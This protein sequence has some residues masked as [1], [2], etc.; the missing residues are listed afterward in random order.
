MDLDLSRVTGSMHLLKV[1]VLAV[2]IKCHGVLTCSQVMFYFS[3][4]LNFVTCVVQCISKSW[5]KIDNSNEIF[6]PIKAKLW[7]ISATGY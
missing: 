2:L 3:A 4:N 5:A 7:M 1:C 6:S